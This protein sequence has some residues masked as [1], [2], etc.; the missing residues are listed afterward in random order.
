MERRGT[1]KSGEW[2]RRIEERRGV[3][4]NGGRGVGGVGRSCLRERDCSCS[5]TV[6]LQQYTSGPVF[7]HLKLHKNLQK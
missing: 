2:V 5:R 1:E 3:E 7:K 4:E 6:V